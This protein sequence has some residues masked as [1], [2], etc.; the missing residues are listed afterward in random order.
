MKN[1]V[2]FLGK[3][4]FLV[5][6]LVG[7]AVAGVTDELRMSLKRGSLADYGATPWFTADVT[8]G[9]SPMQF[10]LDTGTNLFWATLDKCQ[11]EACMNHPR[12][13]T[14]QPDFKII[15][16]P[17]YPKTVNFGPWGTMKVDLAEVPVNLTSK[18]LGAMR[19]DGSINYQGDK[20]K[21]LAWGGGI[22][23]PSE[24]STVSPDISNFFQA[25]YKTG[26]LTMAA[27]SFFTD[28]NHYTG[29]VI[30]GGDDPT[31]Y[32][33]GT[34]V[35]LPAKKSLSPDLSYL[36]GTNLIRGYVGAKEITELAS[37]IFYLDSGSSRFKGGSEYIN[38]ILEQLLTYKDSDGN[39]IFEYYDYQAD[40]GYTGI[41]YAN[42]KS[43]LDYQGILPDFS[44]V[45][46]TTCNA[47]AGQSAKISLSPA[48]YSYKVEAGEWFGEWV[49]A[50]HVLKDVD[51]LLVGS[52]FM[53]L[54]YT[55]FSFNVSSDQTLSQGT[56]AIYKTTTGEQPSG[57]E[58]LSES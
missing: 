14:S 1:L 34:L 57:Y 21:Y 41:K 36:W 13:N 29:T 23:L 24:S 17:N 16:N 8:M 28:A 22:G 39:P 11:T 50:F 10:A 33:A 9:T 19:F 4:M 49:A 56:T 15:E 46:G 37:K 12:V 38:P 7:G 47:Q 58:C 31:L 48:Q 30:L 52:T 40:I 20:F 51:G 53:D 6:A 35:E 3:L 2:T 42:N 45:I 26:S 25:L 32:D 44:L 54:V 55:R 27:I 5:Y 43:P 18:S